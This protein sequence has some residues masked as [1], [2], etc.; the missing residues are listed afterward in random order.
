M[1][2]T[3]RDHSREMVDQEATVVRV[4]GV[5]LLELEDEDGQVDEDTKD[6]VDHL[7]QKS[8]ILS[9]LFGTYRWMC[10]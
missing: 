9:P 7:D 6:S 5:V 1:E 4:E 10:G 3:V 2:P 8:H